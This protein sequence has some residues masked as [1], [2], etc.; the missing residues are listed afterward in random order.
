MATRYIF[1]RKPTRT[2]MS[3]LWAI[4]D[5]GGTDGWFTGMIDDENFIKMEVATFDKHQI[6]EIPEG[7]ARA[8]PFSQIIPYPE[9]V[10]SGEWKKSIYEGEVVHNYDDE[11]NYVD[12][13]W[14]ATG[15]NLVWTTD[16]EGNFT[17]KYVGKYTLT[18]EDIANAVECMKLFKIARLKERMEK[19][20]LLLWQTKSQL[21]K[22]TWAEQA[23]QAQAYRTSENE[24]D[25]PLIGQLAN[26][27]GRTFL[28]QLEKIEEKIENWNTKMVDTL[29]PFQRRIDY[30]KSATD[31][32][33]VYNYEN[34]GA[35][36]FNGAAIVAVEPSDY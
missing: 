30:I 5:F 11:G 23:K 17:P 15:K 27:R 8:V 2:E 21:E 25:A 16:D 7:V 3:D 24:G 13:T 31:F 12:S 18:D 32:V 36:E 28:Q 1:Y 20:W 26:A 9:I 10:E 33:T 4:K 29:G 35:S 19:E 34:P 22:T 14:T 6:Q